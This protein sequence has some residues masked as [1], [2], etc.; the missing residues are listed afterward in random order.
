MGKTQHIA[1]KYEKKNVLEYLKESIKKYPDRDAVVSGDGKVRMTYKEADARAN[2]LANALIDLGVKRGDRIAIFQTNRWQYVE[3]YL[4][5]L[6]LGAIV[7]PMNYRLKGP[8]ALFILNESGAQ[9]LIFE[10]RYLPVFEPSKPYQIGVKNYICT[11]GQ[12]PEW[13]YEYEAL[14]SKYSEEPPPEVEQN[15]DDICSICFTSGT[16]GLP[17]GSISTNRHIMATFHDEIMGGDLV[18][19]AVN[20]DPGHVVAMMVV[21]VYHIA[22]IMMLYVGLSIGATIVIPEAFTTEGFMQTVEREKVT[23]TYLVPL[24]FF[25]IMHDPNFGKYDLSSLKFIPYGAMPMDAELLK[26]I[27]EKFPSHIKYIDAFGST[28]LAI[29]IAKM[30]EDHDLTGTP[31]EVE[32]KLKRLKGIGRPLRVGIESKIVDPMGKEVPTGE[33]GE[34]VSRGDKVTPGYWRNPEKTAEAF[35]KDGWFRTGD[36][37]WRDEDGYFYFSDRASDMINRGGENIYPVE[38]ERVLSE[39]PGVAETAVFGVPDPAWGKIVVAAVVLHQGKSATEQ[40]L[41]DFCKEKIASYKAPSA[42]DFISE[43]PRTFEGGKV[44]KHI[45]RDKFIKKQ[46]GL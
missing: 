45:L 29:N 2:R 46:K 22:G 15:L 41:I 35:D 18:K 26:E 4:A 33:V 23:V 1:V 7:V 11:V 6:K 44:K 24:L 27:L 20:P 40:E 19:K 30:P 25:F 28:E 21:P 43:L 39:H 17:K 38:V 34:I 10:E 31:E 32:K 37:A 5:I 42:I 12:N 8:E 16:T 13:A 3:Q 36:A 14:L 9:T